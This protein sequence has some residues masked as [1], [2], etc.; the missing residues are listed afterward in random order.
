M[1]KYLGYRR[2]SNGYE[3]REKD[4]SNRKNKQIMNA[5][6]VMTKWKKR[7]RNEDNEGVGKK[8]K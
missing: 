7:R 6:K 5:I 1:G 4:R 2:M 8:E 3:A